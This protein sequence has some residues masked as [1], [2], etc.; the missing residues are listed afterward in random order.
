VKVAFSSCSGQNIYQSELSV[1]AT[2][3][4]AKNNA[5]TSRKCSGSLGGV[6]F[7][8]RY[9]ATR[10]GT[11]GRSEVPVIRLGLLVRITTRSACSGL[12]TVAEIPD[13]L[14][15]WRGEARG[16]CYT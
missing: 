14:Q 3:E 16:S 2:R 5:K 15:R 12:A 9:F 6:A 13:V 7:Y 1:N 10:L 11:C 8:S 4:T